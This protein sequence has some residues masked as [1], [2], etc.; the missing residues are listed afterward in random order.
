MAEVQ[1]GGWNALAGNAAAL[2]LLPYSASE[3][4]MHDELKTGTQL[5][6][7]DE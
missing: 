3:K 1:L 7:S 4:R 5:N 6:R 2:M